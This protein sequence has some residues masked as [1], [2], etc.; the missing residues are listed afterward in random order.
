MDLTEGV[1]KVQQKEMQCECQR[2]LKNECAF[3]EIQ[4][5]AVK[6]H[7][8]LSDLEEERVHL[9]KFEIQVQES[10]NTLEDLQAELKKAEIALQEVHCIALKMAVAQG[11]SATTDCGWRSSS[12]KISTVTP[13]NNSDECVL[14]VENALKGSQQELQSLRTENCDRRAWDITA[15]SEVKEKLEA[16][17]LLTDGL[18]G[19]VFLILSCVGFCSF[20]FFRY[21]PVCPFFLFLLSRMSQVGVS[22][23]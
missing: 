2:T 6:A 11:G 7:E 23:L 4:D 16:V 14:L 10:G 13:E 3:H 20:S 15:V 1:A 22:C 18:Q 5:E 21:L 19:Q 17:P 8:G 12:R 9:E